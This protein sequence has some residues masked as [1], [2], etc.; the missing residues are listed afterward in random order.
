MDD[1]AFDFFEFP[2]ANTIPNYS[3]KNSYLIIIN[4]TPQLKILF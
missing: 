2:D 1:I 4:N 3:D